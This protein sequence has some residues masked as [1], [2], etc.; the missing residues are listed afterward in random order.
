MRR[1]C[2]FRVVLAIFVREAVQA[3]LFQSLELKFVSFIPEKSLDRA[4][5]CRAHFWQ[6]CRENADRNGNGTTIRNEQFCSDNC[7]TD[8]D[9]SGNISIVFLDGD[10][11]ELKDSKVTHRT[12]TVQSGHTFLW[13]L[14]L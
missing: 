5:L 4:F 2:L 14:L 11:D 1:I 12:D 3:T 7:S 6:N 13:A 9:A 10:M 8:V